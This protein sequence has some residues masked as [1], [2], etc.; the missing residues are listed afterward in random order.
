MAL[1]HLSDIARAATGSGDDFATAAVTDHSTVRNLTDA[2]LMAGVGRGDEHCLSEL[3]RRHRHSIVCF[4]AA[5]VDADGA[6][7]IAQETFIR[8]SAR[9]AQW[10]PLG[11]LRTYLLHIA[12]NVALNERRR[13]RSLAARLGAALPVLARRSPATPAELLDESELR[14]AVANALDAMPERRRETFALIRFGGLSYAEA[15]AVMGTSEQ[16]TANQM[17]AAMA[18]L[19]RALMPFPDDPA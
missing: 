2:A 17:S 12:R 15:A 6:E 11:P 14:T 16:T 19:R 4:A 1:R 13:Q 9:A 3:Q 7:D 18:D 8:A 5:F 10:R